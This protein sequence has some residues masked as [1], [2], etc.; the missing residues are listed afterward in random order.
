MNDLLEGGFLVVS[1]DYLDWVNA[2]EKKRVLQ[3]ATQDE[4][5]ALAR[6]LLRSRR[7]ERAETRKMHRLGQRQLSDRTWIHT[8]EERLERRRAEAA[9]LEQQ[10]KNIR[11]SQA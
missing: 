3:A 1:E 8:L 7:Q 9:K 11:T 4:P 5:T 6:A 10:L 2:E